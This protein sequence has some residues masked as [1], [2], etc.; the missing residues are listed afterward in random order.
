MVEIMH[1]SSTG[2]QTTPR[3]RGR[4]PRRG[5]N[6]DDGGL[7]EGHVSLVKVLVE[8]DA[9]DV[10]DGIHVDLKLQLVDDKELASHPVIRKRP[11]DAG[12]WDGSQFFSGGAAQIGSVDGTCGPV[13]P[14]NGV[15]DRIK[16]HS[17]HV[18]KRP[19]WKLPRLNGRVLVLFTCA[20]GAEVRWVTKRK[21]ENLLWRGHH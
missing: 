2:V 1:N 19:Q 7:I 8:Y 16:G 13:I 20:A 11:W 14:D 9:G 5:I 3:H 18:V 17:R 10:I 15:V 6:G 4:L 12:G 21:I